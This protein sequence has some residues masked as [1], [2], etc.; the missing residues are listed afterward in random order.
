MQ[1]ATGML[2]PPEQTLVATLQIVPSEQFGNRILYHL[3]PF[4]IFK[5]HCFF[6]IVV[7]LF[8]QERKTNGGIK[9][10]GNP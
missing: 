2:R 7:L 8:S 1:H 4:R 6:S 9:D 10:A 5:K 3:F